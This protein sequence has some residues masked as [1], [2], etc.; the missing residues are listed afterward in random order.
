LIAIIGGSFDP[1]HKGHLHLA[2]SIRNLYKIDVYFVPAYKN[3]LKKV[4]PFAG[5]MHRKRMLELALK[6]SRLKNIYV[7]DY[8]LKRNKP[9][10]TINTVNY[11]LRKF[12]S[13]LFLVIGSDVFMSL[14]CW[15]SAKEL[16]QKANFLVIKRGK[17]NYSMVKKVLSDLGGKDLST[18]CD[19]RFEFL[20]L[21]ILPYSSSKIRNKLKKSV[22]KPNGI[23]NSVW[24]Y[25]KKNGL[26]SVRNYRS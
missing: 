23:F 6:E 10:Y 5:P 4:Y 26:Y 22:K 3:P 17:F 20:K 1:V 7:I 12:N 24:E 2:K 19:A 9:S 25:I 15:H 13:Q 8:E 11:I 14:P 16:A 18:C 21:P